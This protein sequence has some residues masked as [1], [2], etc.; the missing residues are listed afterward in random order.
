M[1]PKI[2]S[3]WHIHRWSWVAKMLDTSNTL[4]KKKKIYNNDL[5]ETAGLK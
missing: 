2:I 4:E 3:N 5:T 1:S